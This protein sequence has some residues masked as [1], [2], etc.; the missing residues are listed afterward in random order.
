MPLAST[1]IIGV[2]GHVDHGKTALVRALTGIETDRLPEERRRGISIALG[3]AHLAFDRGGTVL[4]LIDMPGHERFLRTMIAGATGIGA[5]L[6]VVA[7]NEGIKPQTIEHAEVAAL[8]GV[9]AAVIAVTKCDLVPPERAS[10]VAAEAASLAAGLGLEA[11]APILVSPVANRGI[12]VLKHAL[13]DL[14]ARARRPV[15]RGLG[16]LPIDRS[17]TIAGHGTVVT[18]T[19]RWGPIAVGEDVELV[20]KGNRVRVRGVQVRGLGTAAAAPGQ[21]VAVNL[22]AIETAEARPGLALATPGLLSPSAW[23]SVALRAA[24]SAPAPLGS[25]T[26]L[27]LLFATS[28]TEATVR[29]LD[30][31]EL[32]PGETCLA[33]LRCA[34]RI[35]LPVGEH[36]ILRLTS[37]LRVVAGGRVLDAQAVRL[38]RADPPS[39]AWLETLARAT[40]EAILAAAL[41]RT[42]PRGAKLIAL[43]RL[44]GLSPARIA[45]A[46]SKMPAVIGSGVAAAAPAVER[47]AADVLRALDAHWAA[48]PEGLPRDQLRAALPGSGP[49]VLDMAL[50]RLVAAGRIER[51]SRIRLIRAEHEQARKLSE[52]KLASSLT[53][54]FLRAGLS[55]PTDKPP[56]VATRRALDRLVREGVLIRAPDKAQKRE[57]LFHREAIEEARRRL[58]PLLATGPG[59]LV[60]D[61]GAALGISRK[62]SVPLLEYLDATQFTRRVGDRRQL[63]PAP[64]PLPTREPARG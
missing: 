20:P 39:M 57:I 9:R 31:A 42:G 26:K 25:A 63:R 8:L 29:L 3:F 62:Y 4:D 1:L 37:P 55:P 27:R 41:D 33:Q 15:D 34:P 7:A 47:T 11:P 58:R 21:R 64:P 49:E 40:P 54:A 48:H 14:A 10:S 59:L 51:A 13:R 30:R 6:L 53:T 32:A 35:A 60:S 12:E 45:A 52:D 2:I 16:Y 28:E 44:A 50:A 23:L 46:L 22:R 61:A 24:P 5:V 43:A 38:R 18:G 17:F 19:L 36:V 56:D